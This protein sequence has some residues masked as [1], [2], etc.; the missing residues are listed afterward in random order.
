MAKV[1][2][3]EDGVVRPCTAKTPES[4]TAKGFDGANAKHFDNQ[5]DASAYVEKT[6]N[7]KFGETNTLKKFLKSKNESIS[8][9]K[10]MNKSLKKNKFVSPLVSAKDVKVSNPVVAKMFKV[11]KGPA[12]VNQ[13][14]RAQLFSNAVPVKDSTK[15]AGMFKV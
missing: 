9:N 3:S 2:V 1:H 6:M 7:N 13:Q 12:K 5:A 14:F 11:N 8:E 10:E 4:C 15:V